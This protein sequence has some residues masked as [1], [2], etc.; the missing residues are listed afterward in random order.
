MDKSIAYLFVSILFLACASSKRLNEEDFSNFKN[1][2]ED[3]KLEI[4]FEWANPLGLGNVRGIDK[5]F[6]NGST[7]NNINLIGNQNFFRIKNDSLHIE[8]PYYGTHQITAPTPGANIGISFE[9][10]PKTDT[11]EFDNEKQ[12]ATLKYD[13]KTKNDSYN[14]RL[15][16]FPGNRSYLS[17]TSDRKTAISYTG[18]W[19]VLKKEN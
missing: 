16:L 19:R 14:M 2:I 9:G 4:T 7:Q 6:I 8:L 11:L 12:K 13:F 18:N 17:V 10:I 3:K 15:T 5:L 1:K